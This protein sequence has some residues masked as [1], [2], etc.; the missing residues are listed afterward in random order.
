LLEAT[1]DALADQTFGDFEVIVVDDGSSD[2]SGDAAR[3]AGARLDVTVIAGGGRGA[4]AA[5]TCG[6]EAA[7]GEIVAF[8]DSD[9]IPQ[10]GWLAAG[11]R[12]IDRGADVVQGLT[13]PDGGVRPHERTLWSEHD[14]GLFATC[15]VFYRRDAFDRAGGFD[16]GA[17]DRLGFRPGEALTGLGFGEDTLLGWRV[18]RH[19]TSS[20]APD[21][22]V[23]HHVFPTDLADTARRAWAA[24]GFP[25]LVVEVP[26]LR[27]LLLTGGFILGP[28]S[29]LGLYA[30]V[31]AMV[32]RRPT[33]GVAFLLVWAGGRWRR[34]A[35][36]SG[37]LRRKVAALPADLAIDAVTATALVA[38]SI[39]RRR[40]VL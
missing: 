6:V 21:A 9:C 35:P 31:A 25:G 22:I 5:R 26:E 32:A 10:P 27:H 24:G 40:L 18:R 1:L 4:V 33:I 20:H 13:R 7:R 28:W 12:E 39:R 30:G 2:G 36:L 19:G 38:G 37:S 15:N 3:A 17:G 8:T 23:L 29:R 14:D 34:L 11:V 16:G